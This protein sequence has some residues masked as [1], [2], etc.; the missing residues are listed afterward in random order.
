M[1]KKDNNIIDFSRFKIEKSEE[2]RKVE[3][4][5]LL[6]QFEKQGSRNKVY[7][8]IIIVC[9]V[10]MIVLFSIYFYRQR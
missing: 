3:N 1:E 8:V 4:L 9:V 6:K 10:L 2:K 5:R 7:I